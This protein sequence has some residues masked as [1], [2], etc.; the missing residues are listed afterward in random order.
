MSGV[1]SKILLLSCYACAPSTGTEPG[2]GWFTSH[3]LAAAGHTVH[4]LTRAGNRAAIEAH[5]DST[6]AP[7]TFHYV[8]LPRSLRFL[9]EAS[10]PH[11]LLWQVAALARARH[12]LATTT[13]DVVHHVTYGSIQGASLLWA[14]NRPFY[15]GP[16]G[17]G[18]TAP[19]QARR[20]FGA[21]WRSERLRSALT[22]LLTVSPLHRLMARRSER[23]YA[24]NVQT[25]RVMRRLGARKV[26]LVLDSGLPD[27]MIAD[28]VPARMGGALR[29]LWVGRLLRRKAL[30]LA[31]ESVA[32]LEVPVHLTVVGS[33]PDSAFL[34]GWI[35]ELGLQ[36]RVS[37][38]GRMPWA[39]VMQLYREHDVFLFTSMRDS[40]G[41]QLLE[42]ASQ[43]LPV[44][45][46]DHQGAGDFLPDTAALKVPLRDADTLARD[47][48]AAL[49]RFAALPEGE[50]EAM[51]EAALAFARQH[52]WVQKADGYLRDYA[53]GRP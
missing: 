38:T 29:V 27:D 30:R 17:G 47:V 35:Q 51:G 8:N 9:R 34:P 49:T 37:V 21:A 36:G 42:A 33:G 26:Q 39:D 15:F 46:L 23:M 6:G 1:D 50:R 19:S 11:Y 7:V 24:T 18:Q 40:F 41:S 3:Q 48:G 14:L 22:T 4:V 10:G 44:I 53:E 16:A 52:R 2:F 12:L 5:V 25:A 28:R 32:A 20:Y 31:L 45:C 43:G 13:V